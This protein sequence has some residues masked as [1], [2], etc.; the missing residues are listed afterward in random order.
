MHNPTFRVVQILNLFI[1]YPDT[2]L[3][4]GD[5]VRLTKIPKGTLS[6]ILAELITQ[7]YLRMNKK[8]GFYELGIGAFR[9][10][11]S[12]MSQIGG[13]EIIKAHMKEIVDECGETCQFGILAQGNVLYLH[14]VES[15]NPIKLQ[16][17]VGKMI[18]AF[19]TAIG[20]ALL[21]DKDMQSLKILYPNGLQQFTENTIKGFDELESA[22]KAVRSDGVAYEYGE[23]TKEVACVAVAL[24]SKHEVVAAMSVSLPLFR[25]NKAKMHDISLLL[26]KHKAQIEEAFGDTLSVDMF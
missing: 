20:K 1:Q 21:S 6:P 13:F 3:G 10:G 25:A 17:Y 18:P 16:S 11:A 15:S 26:Q 14:K 7:Q 12:F 2:K 22:L 5:I 4:F 24:Q 23:H 8:G 19:C 9:L